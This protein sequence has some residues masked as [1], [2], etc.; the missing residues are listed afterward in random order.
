VETGDLTS[1]GESAVIQCDKKAVCNLLVK[2][3][4]RTVS[5]PGDMAMVTAA[6]V[7]LSASAADRVEEPITYKAVTSMTRKAAGSKSPVAHALPADERSASTAAMA[8]IVEAAPLTAAVRYQPT[9]AGLAVATTEPSRPLPT[10]LLRQ[11]GR[12]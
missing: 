2:S 10:R 9:E 5:E 8:P 3:A 1:A 6:G 4:S 7:A 11:T 12:W